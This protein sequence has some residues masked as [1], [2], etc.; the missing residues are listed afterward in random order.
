MIP[1][2][3][4]DLPPAPT[5]RSGWPWTE[6]SPSVPDD[7]PWPTVSVI[8]PSFNQAPFIE[9]TIRSVLLQSYP[10]LE[11]LIVDGGSRDGTV[12]ILRRYDPWLRWISEPDRGQTDAIN[13]GL[14][15]A[16]GDILAYL[17]A[18]ELPA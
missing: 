4:A 6:A 11:Y 1:P 7:G 12:E 2:T 13:K 17:N 14:R 10:A 9:E 5:G 15:L 16:T 3:L 18:D 8:T